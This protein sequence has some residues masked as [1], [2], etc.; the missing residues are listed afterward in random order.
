M[1][2]A[3]KCDKCGAFYEPYKI[4]TVILAKNVR[5]TDGLDLC[6]NCM[7]TLKLWL[8]NDVQMVLFSGSENTSECQKENC[9]SEA[10]DD[11]KPEEEQ[12]QGHDSP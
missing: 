6:P 1:S 2:K 3:R 8:N 5:S 7:N 4:D 10:A 9:E 11:R 12:S